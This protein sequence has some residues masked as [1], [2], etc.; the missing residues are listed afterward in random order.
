MG[1]REGGKVAYKKQ[2]KKD[3]KELDEVSKS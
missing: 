2:P 3:A 1:G